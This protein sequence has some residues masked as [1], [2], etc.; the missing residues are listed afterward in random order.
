MKNNPKLV[1][2]DLSIIELLS[3]HVQKMGGGGDPPAKAI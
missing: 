1:M 2:R 3:L